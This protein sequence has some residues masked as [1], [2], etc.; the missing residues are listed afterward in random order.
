M[1]DEIRSMFHPS[2]LLFG[3]GDS[4][5]HGDRR[6]CM[7]RSVKRVQRPAGSKCRTKMLSNSRSIVPSDRK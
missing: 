2:S 7:Y 6:G 5:R 1:K 4:L 3:R